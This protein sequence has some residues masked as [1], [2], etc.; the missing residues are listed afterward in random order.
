MIWIAKPKIGME[1]AQEVLSVLRSG[2]L[3]QGKKV[4]EF[5]TKF[6]DYIGT[7]YA[8]ACSNGTAALHMAMLALDVGPDQECI[9]TPFT[10]IS[11]INMVK[12]VGATPVYVD[13]GDDFNINESLILDQ[14]TEKTKAIIPV[15]LFGKPCN[16]TEIMKIAKK[17]KLKVIEDCAQACGA[18]HNNKK[19]GSFGDV[20]CFSFYPTKIMTTGEGG[21]CTTNSKKIYDK[22]KLI[23]NHG[24]TG[25]DYDYK[26]KGFNYRMSDIEGAIG[27]VQLDKVENFIAVRRA[28]AADYGFY[29]DDVIKFP[30]DRIGDRHVF[31]NYSFRV[32]DR[33]SFILNMKENGIDCRVY[34]SKPFVN[35]PNVKKISEEIVSIPIRPNMT[36]EEIQHIIYNVGETIKWIQKSKETSPT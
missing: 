22:L 18:E 14:I 1:E 33:D 13:V 16:M 30:C 8:V 9:T 12:A 31:N 11:T 6:A 24:M 26:C 7:K 3:A 36:T 27:C 20:G 35:L 4:E 23:R 32:K 17:H 15:H 29:L 34:Y 10:F 28:I 2:M 21:M 25:S 19:V 5:E